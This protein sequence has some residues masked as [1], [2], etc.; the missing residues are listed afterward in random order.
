MDVFYLH[1]ASRN[2]I[3]KL[4]VNVRQ[5]ILGREN[6]RSPLQNV[7]PIAAIVRRGGQIDGLGASVHG[8]CS[9]VW[10]AECALP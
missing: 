6:N 5:T 2:K 10:V 7:L 8:A 4:D 3:S 1:N 9:F